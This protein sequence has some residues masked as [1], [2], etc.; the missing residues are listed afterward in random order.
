M[1]G[2]IGPPLHPYFGD[3]MVR[4][5]YSPQSPSEGV[6][7]R[8]A[9]S[10]PGEIK[11]PLYA[12]GGIREAWLV[13]LDGATIIVHTEPTPEGYASVRAFRAGESVAPRAFPEF[14]V[15]VA[16]VLA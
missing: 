4:K 3:C 2:H 7:K 10:Q 9:S 16:D 6:R 13:D 12:R 5:P 1:G 11:M 14:P 8:P 15:V